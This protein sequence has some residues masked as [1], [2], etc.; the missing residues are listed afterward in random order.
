MTK[1]INDSDNFKMIEPMSRVEKNKGKVESIEIEKTNYKD[2]TK[3]ELI[4]IIEDKDKAY[5]NLKTV[6]EAQEEKSK[7][8]LE[9]YAEACNEQV[10]NL[11]KILSYYENKLNVIKDILNLEGGEK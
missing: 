5:E 9:N 2:F 10:K 8:T 4:R 11:K 1:V 3:D 6:M 7:M